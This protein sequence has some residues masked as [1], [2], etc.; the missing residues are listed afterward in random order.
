M[1]A[2]KVLWRN[3]KERKE[4]ARRLQSQDPGLQVLHPHAAG[5]DVGNSFHYVAVRP[6]RDE[7]PVR[8]FD[9]FTADRHRILRG[10]RVDQ[11][12]ACAVV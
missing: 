9:C 1:T 6:D 10:S 12:L 7:E 5:I 3:R 2:G 11:R 8:K 4:W